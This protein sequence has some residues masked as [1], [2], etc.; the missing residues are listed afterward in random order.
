LE[1]ILMHVLPRPHLPQMIGASLVAVLLA[2]V[3]ALLLAGALS[4][5]TGSAASSVFAPTAPSA[6]VTMPRLTSDV[7]AHPLS[8]PLA[9]LRG[10]PV[11][12]ANRAAG[13]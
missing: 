7:F 8:D 4:G 11:N 12:S 3:I 5:G 6:T 2:I 9:A 1:V 10:A 13:A